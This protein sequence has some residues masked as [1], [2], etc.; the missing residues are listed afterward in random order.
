MIGDTDYELDYTV[1]IE[2]LLCDIEIFKA[3]LEK[4]MYGTIIAAKRARVK[5]VEIEKELKEYRERS[6]SETQKAASSES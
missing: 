3:D 5:S 6:I 1:F 4:S 2:R